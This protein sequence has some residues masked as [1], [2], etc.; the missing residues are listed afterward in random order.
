MSATTPRLAWTAAC[1]AAIVAA[2]VAPLGVALAV[3]PFPTPRPFWHEFSVAIGFLALTLSVLQFALISRMG[4]ASRRFGADRLLALHRSAGVLT[5]VFIVGHPWLLTDVAWRAWWPWSASPALRPGAFALWAAVIVVVTSLLRRRLGLSYERWQMVHVAG[6]TALVGGAALHIWRIGGY[7]RTPA[8]RGTVAA[9]V[10]AFLWLLLRRRVVRPWRLAGRPWEITGNREIG[11]STRLIAL[12]PIGHAGLRFDAGQFAWLLTGRTPFWSQQHPL[13]IASAVTPDAGAPI[14]FAI[15]ALGDWSSRTVPALSPGTRVWVDGPYGAFC[16]RADQ[17]GRLVL[18]AGGIGI[19]PMR[20]I[21]LTMHARGST[22]P[23]TLIHAA[24]TADRAVCLEELDGLRDG[25]A[26][27]IVRVFEHGAKDE[28]VESG[29]VTSELIRRRVPG[30]PAVHEYFVCGP[31]PM[32]DAVS[33]ALR[34]IGVPAR[35]I[36]SERFQMV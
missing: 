22:R 17:G 20:S 33:R 19:A 25:L 5:L 18:I 15:K 11:G 13:S 6:A 24:S 26:L 23:V 2:I 28:Q 32:I 35:A 4:G 16:P 36:H 14:E 30:D 7:A 27:E 21:L 9:A 31:V 3:D 34:Q 12:R 1:V 8:M 29:L 10:A